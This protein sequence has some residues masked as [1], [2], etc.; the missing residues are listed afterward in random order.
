MGIPVATLKHMLV[1]FARSK[2]TLLRCRYLASVCKMYRKWK[3]CSRVNPSWTRS[4][5][6]FPIN[7]DT[8][9]RQ[10]A[11]DFYQIRCIRFESESSMIAWMN[12][13]RSRCHMAEKCV[14]TFS[15]I[16][17]FFKDI[18]ERRT[19]ERCFKTFKIRCLITH[20]GHMLEVSRNNRLLKD[21]SQI[22]E[23]IL[24]FL[25]LHSSAKA[26]EKVDYFPE[27]NHLYCKLVLLSKV[28]P[29]W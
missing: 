4:V 12:G 3:E 19:S 14:H 8:W 10:I 24:E 11:C 17:S 21:I 16:A 26:R 23:T 1:T 20:L 7:C 5:M 22:L 9:W 27:H 18:G 13:E 15:N 25:L 2:N 6:P 28:F 29:R